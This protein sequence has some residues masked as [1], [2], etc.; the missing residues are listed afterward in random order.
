M[1]M[2]MYTSKYIHEFIN[3]YL[4]VNFAHVND[5]GVAMDMTDDQMADVSERVCTL[6]MAP[7][8]PFS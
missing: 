6:Q 8:F 3:I 5:L 7:A 1:R 4:C 2:Y